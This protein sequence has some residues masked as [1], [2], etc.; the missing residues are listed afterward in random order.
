MPPVARSPQGILLCK[1]T[2]G[3]EIKRENVSL[4]TI[5]GQDPAT[6][7]AAEAVYAHVAKLYTRADSGETRLTRAQA[8]ALD[9]IVA[10]RAPPLAYPRSRA[11][12]RL[13]ERGVI[14]P[15]PSGE[16]SPGGNVWIPVWS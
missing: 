16:I 1:T 11:L 10:N 14:R 9:D 7:N 8:E 4:I 12:R 15:R 3:W 13:R 2:L 6:Q 5:H